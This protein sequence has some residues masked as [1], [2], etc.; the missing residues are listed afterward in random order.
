[1]NARTIKTILASGALGASLIASLA[2]NA[3]SVQSGPA[4]QTPASAITSN[5][6]YQ[7]APGD[8]LSINV[9]GFQDLTADSTVTPDGMITVPLLGQVKASGLTTDQL[10][11]QL[12]SGWKK[13]VVNPPV[14][15]SVKQKH[16]QIFSVE[17]YVNHP[18][19]A[20]FTPNLHIVQALALAGGPTTDGD[21]SKVTVTHRD[22]TTATVNLSNPSIKGGTADDI[23]VYEQDNIYVPQALDKVQ[24]VGAVKTPGSYSLKDGMTALDAI[25]TAGGVLIDNADW[26]HTTL[27]RGGVEKPMDIQA[28]VKSGDT[29]ENIPLLAGD[30]INIPV[31]YNRVYVFGQVNKPGYA[32]FRPG[33][34]V[35]DALNNAG[36]MSDAQ[37]YKVNLIKVDKSKNIAYNNVID[38][39]S[40]LLKGNIKGNPAL[41]PGDVLYI[42]QKRV[43][44]EIKD[45]LGVL[46][47][48]NVLN[49]GSK[50]VTGSS[51]TGGK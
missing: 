14:S 41:Q 10:G 42:P 7:I 30:K 8:V 16:D 28:L 29:K 2:A 11:A 12:A 49:I 1:M 37:I 34:R 13:Y 4:A 38:V 9:L 50:I 47:S 46:S 5:V 43:P 44:F 45:M 36:L 39:E 22:G 19:P 40:F 18:G 25:T 21:L 26:E 48:L 27:T 31:I 35:L 32:E 23:V 15:V 17:G 20:T 33:D 24:V 6:A 51:L 3:A